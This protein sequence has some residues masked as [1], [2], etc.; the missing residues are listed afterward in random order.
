MFGMF[1]FINWLSIIEEALVPL[2]FER[3]Y[4]DLTLRLKNTLIALF[5]VFSL[6]CISLVSTINQILANIRSL[7][8]NIEQQSAAVE[9]SSAAV[10]QM[11]ANIQGVTNV[12]EKNGASTRELAGASEIGQQ[13]V[14]EA[15]N[16]SEKI[17]TE[18]KGLLEAS[19]VVQSIAS[20]TNLLAMNAA[21][22]AAHAGDAGKEFSVVA[23]EI[24]KL[25]EQSNSHGKKITESLKGLETVN[26]GVAAST[27]EL[28]KQFSSI[29]ELTKVVAQQEEVVMDAMKEQNEGS[30]QIL[31]AMGNIDD[32]TL[33]V[34][35]GS[36]EM[37]IGSNQLAKGMERLNDS[38]STLDFV[39]QM[40][41][42]ADHIVGAVELGD[43]VC[44]AECHKYQQP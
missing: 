40:P 13:K 22:E 5:S 15:V 28:E 11:V 36:S 9:E 20:Q 14:Q 26:A 31:Q 21:I 12:L 43:Q 32:I 17:L 8:N 24:R 41:S 10:N 2:R 44:T 27:A 29:Y 42:G 6:S 18:S 34:K 37:L 16:L 23:D 38:S 4:I 35:N 25:A 1:F 30:K 3:K 33:S 19:T 7:N 39:K